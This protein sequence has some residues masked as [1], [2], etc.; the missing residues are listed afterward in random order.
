MTSDR[1]AGGVWRRRIIGKPSIWQ[2]V[3]W[4]VLGLVWIS[5]TIFDPGHVW[6][7][8]LGG[9]YIVLGVSTLAAAVQDYRH[10]RGRYAQR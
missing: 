1:R 7:W 9:L 3:I 10:R 2:G 4:T 8:V 5:L 6:R